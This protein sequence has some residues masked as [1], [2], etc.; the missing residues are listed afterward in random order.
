VNTRSGFLIAGLAA[1]LLWA[2]D[3]SLAAD[4]GAAKKYPL[5]QRGALQMNVPAGWADEVRQPQNNAPPT[6]VFGPKEGRAFQVL[7]TPLWRPRPDVPVATKEAV[8]QNV[9]R[10]AEDLKSQAVETTIPIV[11]FTGAGG[12][13][14][15]FSATDK[16]P[17]PD[18]YK[19]LTQGMLKVGELAVTFTIL[20]NEGPERV[21]RDALNMLQSAMHLQP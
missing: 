6:I 3:V 19:Y 1:S 8:R 21:T 12:P 16:A 17:K 15:Y 20:S 13:G 14:F 7:V 18:E 9:Q 4:A 10:A 5:P 2:V 11:E